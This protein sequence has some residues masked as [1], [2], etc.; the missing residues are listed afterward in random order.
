M[1]TIPKKTNSLDQCNRFV[2]KLQENST[3]TISTPY[4]NSNS[5][6]DDNNEGGVYSETCNA[7]NF[8][9]NRIETCSSDNL[10]FR[11]NEITISNDVSIELC[12]PYV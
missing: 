10:I 9:D 3:T 7:D 12:L 4:R 5:Y 6:N 8:Y 2:S 11:D 1:F